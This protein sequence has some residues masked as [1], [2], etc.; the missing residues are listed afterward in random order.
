M[1]KPL[2]NYFSKIGRYL[3]ID[4]LY[5]AK[6]GFWLTGAQIISVIS[7]LLLSFIYA[8]FLSKVAF[9]QYAYILSFVAFFGSFAHPGMDKAVIRAVAQGRELIAKKA[10]KAT[11]PWAFGAALPLVGLGI[12]YWLKKPPD[13]KLALIFFSTFFLVIPIWIFRFFYSYFIAK[14]KLKLFFT[15]TAISQLVSLILL[16]TISIVFSSGLLLIT[17][18]L[19]FQALFSLSYSLW[20]Y[21]QIRLIPPKSSDFTYAHKLNDIQIFLSLTQYADKIILAKLLGFEAV[22][23]FTFAKV[24][25]EQIRGFLKHISVL[26]LPK[27]S[28]VNMSKRGKQFENKLKVF[29]I[30]TILIIIA[31]VI[32][33]PFIFSIFFPSYMLSIPLSRILSLM[34]LSAPGLVISSLFESQADVKNLRLQL[35]PAYGLQL[36]LLG[37]L[38]YQFGIEGTAWSIAFGSIL[39]T[40]LGL[41]LFKRKYLS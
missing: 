25:P 24:V 15:A 20:I 4:F 35:Y 33:S 6:G 14:N 8:R 39:F 26:A 12:F 38:T 32:L 10:T 30:M 28:Q 37:V 31:F 41:I 16:A 2:N 1:N 9:G 17:A 11:I 34:I 3:A 7:G 18:G 36:V 5:F 40:G 22:A 21:R 13:P 29:L 27:L 19:S 23:I